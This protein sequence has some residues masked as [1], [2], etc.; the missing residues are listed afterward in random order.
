MNLILRWYVNMYLKKGGYQVS[1]RKDVKRRKEGG[2][3]DYKDASGGVG[4]K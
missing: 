1:K 2:I 4:M 3:Q